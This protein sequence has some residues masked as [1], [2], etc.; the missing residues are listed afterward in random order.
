MLG[1]ETVKEVGKVAAAET[2]GRSEVI[3]GGTPLAERQGGGR[4]EG[5]GEGEGPKL[6][7]GAREWEDGRGWAGPV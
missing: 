7:S 1:D 3:E 4:R 6:V 2:E 5:R